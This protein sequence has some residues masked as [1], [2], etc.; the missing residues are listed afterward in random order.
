MEL[1]IEDIS[2]QDTLRIGEWEQGEAERE[3]RESVERSLTEIQWQQQLN[4]QGGDSETE[5]SDTRMQLRKGKEKEG[6]AIKTRL[7][8]RWQEQKQR[9]AETEQTE[10]GAEGGGGQY[11]PTQITKNPRILKQQRF[12]KVKQEKSAERYR[13]W[14]LTTLWERKNWQQNPYTGDEDQSLYRP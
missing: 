8:Q 1:A 11:P 13:T 9:T 7:Q 4:L 5:N 12:R 3:L 6:Q 14:D 10:K 2:L